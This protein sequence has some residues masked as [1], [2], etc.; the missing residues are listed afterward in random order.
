MLGALA[1][2]VLLVSLFDWNWLRGPL[3][4]YITE[5][6]HR[7]F[8]SSDLHVQLG[9]NPVVRLRDVYFANADWAK[10]APMAKI[11][12][13]EF[14]V[15]LRDLFDGKVLVPRAALDNAELN[16]E[17]MAD[18]RRNWVLQEPSDSDT[19]TRL[20]IGSLSI[21]QGK[22]GFVDR[23]IPFRIGIDVSTFDA[24]ARQKAGD[25]KAAPVNK[26]YTTLFAFEGTYHDA[27]FHGN[28]L[29]GDVLSFQESNIEF[30]IKGH[31]VAGTTTLDLEG[32]VADAAKLSGIDVRLKMAGQTLANLYPFL[33]LPLPATPPYQVQ[34]HL[35]MK[36]NRYGMDEIRGQ[37]GST[38]V[39]G[40]A[41]YV[42]QQPRPL[43]QAKLHSKLL[44]LS[45][46][47]PVIGITTKTS[48]D[49][50]PATQAETNTRETAKAKEQVASGGKVLPDGTVKGERLLPTGSFEGSR[51]KAIDAEVDMAVDK[52]DAPDFIALQKLRVGLRLK[53][54]VMNLDP[55]D[56][57]LADGQVVSRLQ[58]DAREPTLKAAV[59]IEARKLRLA[60]LVPP[61]PRLAPSK[62]TVGG[63][64]QLRGTGNSIADAAAKANGQVNAVLS[65]GQVSN[66]LDAAS[67]LNGGKVI[68]LLMGGDKPI[69]IRCGAASFDVK[70]GLGLS[71]VFVVDTEE[72]RIDGSGG[73]DLDKELFDVT[74]APQPKEKGILSLRTPLRLHG[75]FRNP[76]FELDK[77]GLALRGGGAVVLALLNPLA[78]LLPLIETGPGSDTDCG[79]LFAQAKPAAQAAGQGPALVTDKT[80]RKP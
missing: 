70:N 14:S 50:A 16:F 22:V 54:A 68:S 60:K 49:K 8:N 42:D 7:E 39:A 26:A 79:R 4:R 3:N 72:T 2:M 73:F 71:K 12:T 66:L 15:S 51:F 28:A 10:D 44:K 30:P 20:R 34:G 35:T 21:T 40:D 25:A 58:L 36:G 53:D 24:N 59:D 62:G 32:R 33:L 29:T 38:D 47:G 64:V 48:G 1:V 6:T 55:F 63:R 76:D 61:S 37:I 69:A 52:I 13:L 75:S 5:K 80:A 31:L 67:G 9:W 65:S 27:K 46:L 11:G 78:A 23:G 19:P 57:D 17:R 77:K 74:I 18:D 43:L 41:A 56:F 45:D